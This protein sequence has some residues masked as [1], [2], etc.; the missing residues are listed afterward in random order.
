LGASVRV[1][2]PTLADVNT[3]DENQQISKRHER[4]KRRAIRP[5][6]A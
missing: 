4:H 5:D 6:L 1:D 2:D 3:R